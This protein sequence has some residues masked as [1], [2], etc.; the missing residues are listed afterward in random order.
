[1]FLTRINNSLPPFLSLHTQTH[2][3][4]IL[5]KHDNKKREEIGIIYSSIKTKQLTK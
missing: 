3:H 5:S 2:A 1:M 4:N